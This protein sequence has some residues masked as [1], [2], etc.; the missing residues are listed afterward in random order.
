MGD[1]EHPKGN[2]AVHLVLLSALW[3]NAYGRLWWS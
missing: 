1:N 3:V 2:A